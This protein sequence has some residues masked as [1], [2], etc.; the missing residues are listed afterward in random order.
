LF[1]IMIIYF[2]FLIF[3]FIK[4]LDFY[5]APRPS[6]GAQVKSEAFN[7]IKY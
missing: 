1:F 3:N 4:N 2:I 7:E 6:A 5:R